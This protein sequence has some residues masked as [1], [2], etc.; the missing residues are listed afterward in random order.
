MFPFIYTRLLLNKSIYIGA[1]AS[2]YTYFLDL[3]DNI[4]VGD[5]NAI[6]LS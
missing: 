5:N 2:V 3:N 1:I 4:L 6:L